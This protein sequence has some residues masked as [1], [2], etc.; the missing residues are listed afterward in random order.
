MPA[1]AA[2]SWRSDLKPPSSAASSPPPSVPRN[3]RVIGAHK[4]VTIYASDAPT[5]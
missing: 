2:T 1:P 4:R 3:D 5:V